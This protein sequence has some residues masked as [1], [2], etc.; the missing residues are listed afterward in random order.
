MPTIYCVEDD[1]NIRELIVYALKNSNFDAVGF[2]N[3][4]EFYLALNKSVPD[5]VLLDIMLP[6]EDGLSILKKTK[7]SIC[8]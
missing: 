8:H 6:G 7:K 1:E 4:E 3:A 2:E 5:L